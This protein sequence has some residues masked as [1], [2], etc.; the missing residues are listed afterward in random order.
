MVLEINRVEQ[1]I[2]VDLEKRF[3][4]VCEFLKLLDFF[5]LI[6]SRLSVL[7]QFCH[8]NLRFVNSIVV[9]HNH[10]LFA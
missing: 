10:S 4:D 3:F 5:K 1:A 9:F 2:C 8:A 7:Y 6:L